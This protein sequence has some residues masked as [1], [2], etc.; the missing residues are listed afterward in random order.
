MCMHYVLLARAPVCPPVPCVED[1]QV[2]A[3]PRARLPPHRAEPQHPADALAPDVDQEPGVVQHH[4][5]VVVLA[6]RDDDDVRCSLV[7]SDV[8]TASRVQQAEELTTTN[9]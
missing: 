6:D 2:R 3:P 9:S 7:R 5:H 8:F 1:E 4:R